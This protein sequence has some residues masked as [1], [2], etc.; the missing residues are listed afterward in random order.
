[1]VCR[2]AR[3]GT[4]LFVN[5]AYAEM[6]ES[7]PAALTGQNLWRVV[8]EEDR[9]H[10][11]AQLELLRPD[12]PQVVIENRIETPHGTRWTLWRNGAVS[13]DA[14]GQ[15]QVAQ[16]TG[17]DITERKAL[18]EQR[19]LL[20]DE[21]N[22]RVRNTLMVV[23]GMAYQSFR[24]DDV[25]QAALA[26]FNARLHALAG[27]HTVL[28][29]SSWSGA[30]MAE[31]LR[32]GLAICGEGPG[33][34]GRIALDGEALSLRPAVAVALVLVLHELATNALKYG[35]L[36]ADGGKVAI[37]WALSGQGDERRV[38]LTWRES[39]GPPVARPESQGF[40]SRLIEASVKR[41]LGGVLEM[42]FAPTGLVCRM[43]IPL[44]AEP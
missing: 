18:E 14:E 22:H 26:A 29:R 3:D 11:S 27:A 5:R 25:P 40:G 37:S 35:A 44:G 33:G 41:Q 42:D 10:V 4:I 36:C 13:F 34:G 8:T 20:I 19:K 32:Q 17:F 24:G 2:F 9:R 21:L 7:T 12:H 39:G 23:Q 16:S 43:D 15:W 30:D 1:M 38:A 28:S 6:L 31:V